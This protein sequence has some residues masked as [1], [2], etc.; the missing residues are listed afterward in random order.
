LNIK[1]TTKL[2]IA[3]AIDYNGLRNKVQSNYDIL[4]HFYDTPAK[5]GNINTGR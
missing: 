3:T 2:F 5:S 4:L 1:I